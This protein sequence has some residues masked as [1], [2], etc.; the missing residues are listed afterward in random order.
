MAIVLASIAGQAIFKGAKKFLASKGGKLIA[1]AAA[2]RIQQKVKS[3]KASKFLNSAKNTIN[4]MTSSD[5]GENA[6]N[7]IRTSSKA[8]IADG[9][10]VEKSQSD[11]VVLGG[12]K[13]GGMGGILIA[14]IAALV[15]LPA[16]T[17]K[18]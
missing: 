7:A 17:K 13:S 9:R 3:G 14:A 4:K 11:G 10:I 5:M 6:D 15:L 16:L 8:L 2:S 1:K 12:S 18:R